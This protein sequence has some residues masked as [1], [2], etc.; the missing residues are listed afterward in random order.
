M[1]K[2]ARVLGSVIK[3]ETWQDRENINTKRV[4]LLQQRVQEKLSFLARTTPNTTE[5]LQTCE[6]KLKENL[7][8]NVIGKDNISH[9]LRDL[10]FL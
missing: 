5:N 10:A 7:I 6:K 3:S 4:L 2:G 9:Q 8:P 1:K